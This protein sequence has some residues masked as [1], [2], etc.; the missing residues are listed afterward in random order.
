M[1]KNHDLP[2]GLTYNEGHKRTRITKRGNS[3]G[4]EEEI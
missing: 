3:S 2:L 1:I 4:G